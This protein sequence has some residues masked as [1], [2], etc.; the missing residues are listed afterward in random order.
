MLVFKGLGNIASLMKNAQ[1]I[2]GKIGDVSN[3]L[4]E[5]RATG[6]AGGG[7]VEVEVNGM[8]QVLKV[9][10]EPSL[11]EKGEQE[12]IQDLLPAAINEATAKAKQMHVEAMKE[13]TGGL[14]L[15][16]LDEAM[17]QY[18]GGNPNDSNPSS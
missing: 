13:I 11:I 9:Q 10:I 6:T 5:K 17:E 7:M 4:K 14:P 8:G 12:M 18:V 3:D 15:P 1:A 2:T 16:G